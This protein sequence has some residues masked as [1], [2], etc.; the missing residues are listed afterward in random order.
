M[1]LQGTLESPSNT[2]MYRGGEGVVDGAKS[3][4]QKS[5]QDH[6]SQG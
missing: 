4:S 6:E 2:D 3:G 5:V 1:A